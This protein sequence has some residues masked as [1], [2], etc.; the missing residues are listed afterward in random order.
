MWLDYFK[1]AFIYDR[2]WKSRLQD[3]LERG[4]VRIIR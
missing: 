4:N 3:E 2:A 1:K